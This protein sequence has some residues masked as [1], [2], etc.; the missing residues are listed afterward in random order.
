MY[1][2][3]GVRDAQA[4]PA[5]DARVKQASALPKAIQR[6]DHNC[7][8]EPPKQLC[9]YVDKRRVPVTVKYERRA[10]YAG[11]VEC[12][13]CVRATCTSHVYTLALPWQQTRQPI[14]SGRAY[15]H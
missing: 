3:K 11:W 7:R 13:S 4:Q 2:V 1:L 6:Q 10:K 8:Q 5:E 9:K 14:S 12:C 15:A